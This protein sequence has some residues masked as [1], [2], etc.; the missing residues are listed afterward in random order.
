MLPKNSFGL[1][2]GMGLLSFFGYR[3]IYDCGSFLEAK[4]ASV[5]R[6]RGWNWSPARSED[7]VHIQS[8]LPNSNI[9]DANKAIW[10]T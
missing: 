10:V 7:L 2:W 6:G 1:W 5:I 9:G 3:V 4:L 8:P